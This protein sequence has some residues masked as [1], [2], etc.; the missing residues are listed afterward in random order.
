[1]YIYK[2]KTDFV[3][4]MNYVDDIMFLGA[5]K[6]LLNKVAKQMP[7]RFEMSDVSDVSRISS[8]YV[9]RVCKKRP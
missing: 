8:I 9:T 1:M 5:S 4:F 3:I 7:G 2:A 6:T